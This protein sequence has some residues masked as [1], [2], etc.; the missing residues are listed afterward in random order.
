[1]HQTIGF[2]TG[3]LV[4]RGACH[5]SDA[6]QSHFV[7]VDGGSTMDRHRS[8]ATFTDGIRSRALSSDGDP[9]MAIDAFDRSE[10]WR[11]ALGGSMGL[12]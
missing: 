12:R 4:L 11:A 7:K 1:M 2:E 3:M 9:S 8:S 10:P 6:T 5:P